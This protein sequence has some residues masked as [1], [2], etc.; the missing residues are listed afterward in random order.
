MRTRLHMA[1]TLAALTAIDAGTLRLLSDS[2]VSVRRE[3]QSDPRP[4]GHNGT[5]AMARRVRQMERAAAK[6]ERS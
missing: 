3:P 2:P 6:R 1:A 4:P 5:R